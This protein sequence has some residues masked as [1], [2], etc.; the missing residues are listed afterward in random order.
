MMEQYDIQRTLGILSGKLDLVLE[1]Q[2]D[3]GSKFADFEKRLRSLESHRGYAFG[4][5]AAAAFI[6]TVFFEFVKNKIT[7]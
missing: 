7:N 5:I 6:W 2:K 1:N 4:I 3:F